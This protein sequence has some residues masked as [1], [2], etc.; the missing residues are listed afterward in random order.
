MRCFRCLVALLALAAANL[1]VSCRSAAATPPPL[2]IHVPI[3]M[4]HHISD[5][6]RWPDDDR[7]KRLTVLPEQ[8]AEQLEYLQRTGYTTITLD[9]LVA[10]LDT[11]APLPNKPVI[12]TFDDG[13]QDFYINAYPLLQRY[14]AKATIYIVSG[15]VGNPDMMTWDELHDLA[16]SPLIT[17]GGHTRTH[18]SLAK[19]SAKRGQEELAGGKA[20]LEA[21]LH[22]VVRHL[23]YPGDSY[24]ATT[25]AL[26][27]Q[28][29]YV[30]ATTVRYGIREN[31]DKLLEL[32]RVFVNGGMPLD[33]LITGLEGRR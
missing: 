21:Q 25:I 32:P 9:D 2:V 23:A 10:A 7:K 31:R 4:Y 22:V 24:N 29:G 11:G 18:A 17:I 33:D 8:F 12:L 13:Y 16:A 14:S 30:S 3:L 19:H 6:S 5:N 20:D 26:A 28:A 15:W 27:R 1:L